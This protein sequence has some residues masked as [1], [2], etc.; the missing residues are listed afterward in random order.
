VES[1]NARLRVLQHSRRNVSDARLG[2]LAFRWNTSR[3]EE[4]PR[5]LQITRQTF[6]LIEKED[7]RTW[8]ELLPDSLPDD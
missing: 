2:L 7:T 3:R 4:G 8:G 5:R 1:F 6:G